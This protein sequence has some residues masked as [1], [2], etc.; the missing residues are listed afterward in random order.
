MT[1]NVNEAA[2]RMEQL[3]NSFEIVPIKPL[4]GKAI[5][6]PSDDP[7][8]LGKGDSSVIFRLGEFTDGDYLCGKLYGA[9]S[10]RY[11]SG[12]WEMGFLYISGYIICG[13][14][15]GLDNN[16]DV[17]SR[18]GLQVPPHHQFKAETHGGKFTPHYIIVE[19][20]TQG[21]RYNVVDAV[22]FDFNSIP[23]GVSLEKAYRKTLSR[24]LRRLRSKKYV[25][26]CHGHVSEAEGGI[27][28]AIEH[29]FFVQHRQNGEGRLIVGDL[30]HIEA[31][32]VPFSERLPKWIQNFPIISNLGNP[33]SK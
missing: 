24:T 20:F 11:S 10:P 22:D 3:I 21:G 32:Y 18:V 25:L 28:N 23:N 31:R 8:I 19:D 16:I 26:H 4:A 12:I 17:L 33:R 14:D 15:K 5:K 13:Y 7:C 29:L 27:D 2:S 1:N 6:V 30:D 9:R